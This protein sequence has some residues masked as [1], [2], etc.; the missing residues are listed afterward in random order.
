MNTAIHLA[1]EDIHRE[2][3]EN[4]GGT[5]TEFTYFDYLTVDL[6][7]WHFHL[8][9][10]AHQGAGYEELARKCRVSRIAFVETQGG[11]CGEGRTWALRLWNGFGEQ[12][13]TIFLPSPF[14]SD[15]LKVL[16]EPRWER[17]RLWYELRHAFLGEEMPSALDG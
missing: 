17:L 16:K 10:G 2:T 12:M 7:H 8:C 15:D 3:V 11:R 13:T 6:G 9:I 5:T 1:R 4:P 14:L